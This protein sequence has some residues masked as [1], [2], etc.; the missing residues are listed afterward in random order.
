M[1]ARN[2]VSIAL[3]NSWNYKLISSKKAKKNHADKTHF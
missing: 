3:H 1:L 2:L